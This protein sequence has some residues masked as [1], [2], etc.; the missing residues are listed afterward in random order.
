MID[1]GANNRK[2]KSD[3]GRTAKA[4]VFQHWQT[5]I[6]IHGQHRIGT[7]EM[8]GGKQGVSGQGADKIDALSAKL[9]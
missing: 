6:V 8:F 7:I 2:A 9:C 1:R 5:L 3:I 4:L